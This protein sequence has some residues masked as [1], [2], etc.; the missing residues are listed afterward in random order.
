MLTNIRSYSTTIVQNNIEHI[1]ECAR[2]Q[3][4]PAQNAALD[5]LTFVVNQ[6]LYSPVHVSNP[7]TGGIPPFMANNNQYR[8]SL[9]LSH[10]KPP[11]IPLYLN[12]LSLFITHFTPSV[13]ALSMCCTWIRPK[14]LT[15]ISVVSLQSPL[16]IV[17]VWLCYQS[18]M[19][20]CMR[21]G[22]GGTIF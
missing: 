19:A 10:W 6:G 17:M 18:G 2:S 8:L 14:H 5:V 15:N 7:Q 22:A 21:R 1:F 4:I 9:S 13:R 3:H 11:K 20:C 16:D 12:E